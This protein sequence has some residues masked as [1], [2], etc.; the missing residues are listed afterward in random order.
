LKVFCHFVFLALVLTEYV[1][2]LE[3]E[4]TEL[5]SKNRTL[6]QQIDDMSQSTKPPRQTHRETAPSHGGVQAQDP[7]IQAHIKQLNGTVGKNPI[8][9]LLLSV[10]SSFDL[11]EI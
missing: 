9:Y 7:F 4:I 6:R 5:K 3:K 10:S 8:N 2:S 1:E 11:Q